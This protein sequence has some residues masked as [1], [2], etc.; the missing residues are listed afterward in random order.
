MGRRFCPAKAIASILRARRFIR[1]SF[2]RAFALSGAALL[3]G[4]LPF[5]QHI[6]GVYQQPGSLSVRIVG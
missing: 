6:R 3:A 4:A 1:F 2:A 5:W